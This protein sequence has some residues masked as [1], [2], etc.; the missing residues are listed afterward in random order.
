MGYSK[1]EEIF[2]SITHGIGSLLSIAALV[3]MVVFAAIYGNVWQV[4][5][6]AIYGGTLVILYTMSTL[7]HAFTNRTA[8]YIFKIFDH[9]SIYLLIAGT[10]TPYCLV[11]LR[12]YS[13]KGWIIF[14]LIW[15]AAILGIILSAVFPK[16]FKLLN[17]LLYIIMGWAII[18]AMP[19]LYNYMITLSSIYGIYWLILG[20]IV[21]TLGIIFYVIKKVPYFH[22]IWHIFVLLGSICHFISIFFYVL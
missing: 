5:S 3:I 11:I 6:V 9:S 8:K 16:K 2:N 14:G 19:D 12:E 18:I 17:M 1:G 15:V 4:V 10:Y 7:Y 21:Y 20:G 22:S 13:F